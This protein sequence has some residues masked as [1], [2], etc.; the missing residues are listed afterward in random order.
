[1]LEIFSLFFQWFYFKAANLPADTTRVFD[2]V[3]AGEASYPKAWKGTWAVISYDH[4]EWIRAQTAYDTETGSLKITVPPSAF[5]TV[6]V[7]YFE[8]FSYHS[9]EVLIGKCATAKDAGGNFIAKVTSVATSLDNRDIDLVT[10]GTGPLKCW[11]VARQHPG[12]SMAE[13]WMNGFLARLLDPNDALAISI[14]KQATIYVVPNMNPDGSIRGY[15]RTNAS[16]ANLNREWGN[17]GDHVAPS[18]ERSPE[19]YGVLEKVKQTGCDLFLDVVSLTIMH[20][21]VLTS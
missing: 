1:M 5:S 7:A 20:A 14:R 9:H 16:G 8:P 4:Q 10:T 13:H 15:L 2:I 3:N 11:L 17:T 18:L 12:E 21:A 19:V 6:W